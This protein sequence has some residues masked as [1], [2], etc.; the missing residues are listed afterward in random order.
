[1]PTFSGNAEQ[2]AKRLIPGVYSGQ[3]YD[4]EPV[5]LVVA[6][7]KATTLYADNPDIP[8]NDGDFRHAVSTALANTPIQKS[9]TREEAWSDYKIV[10]RRDGGFSVYQESAWRKP[11][12]QPLLAWSPPTGEIVATVSLDGTV[13]VER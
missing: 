3:T 5:H 6:H 12:E 4:G 11:T 1:M 2:A 8:M 9:L 7:D 13:I 10:R